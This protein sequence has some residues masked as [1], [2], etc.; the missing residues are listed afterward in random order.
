MSGRA[1]LPGVATLV[2]PPGLGPGSSPPQCSSIGLFSF[3]PA[4][5]VSRTLFGC[6]R[7]PPGSSFPGP[8]RMRLARSGAADL[9]SISSLC[10][11]SRRRTVLLAA[12]TSSGGAGMN[13]AGGGIQSGGTGT[14]SRGTG[15]NS[16][17]GG[18][19]WDWAGTN[20]G[21]T[22]NSFPI[23]SQCLPLYPQLVPV[24]P[25]CIPVSPERVG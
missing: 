22:G 1:G 12:P 6:S 18:M 14:H 13:W 4:G 19:R 10:R 21:T 24:S 16:V 20:W 15:M 2:V 5:L 25:Q 17:G 23:F 8:P 3:L 7:P 11:V 9:R